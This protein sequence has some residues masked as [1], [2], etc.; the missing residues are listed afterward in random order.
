MPW[1]GV[2]VYVPVRFAG[3]GGGAGFADSALVA[4]GL[5]GLFAADFFEAMLFFLEVRFFAAGAAFF[6]MGRTVPQP[7]G[8]GQ[9]ERR[10]APA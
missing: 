4:A 3:G 8:G 7:P 5:A 6:F 9:A 2:G 1:T 10:D